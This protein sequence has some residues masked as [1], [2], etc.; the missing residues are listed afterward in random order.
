LE[1]SRLSS[2]ITVSP[3]PEAE[4]EGWCDGRP[5]DVDIGFEIK[6]ATNTV[7]SVS[8]SNWMYC[9]GA[10]HGY[11]GTNGAT[12]I[13]TPEPHLLKASDLFAADS[14]WKKYLTDQCY[15]AMMEKAKKEEITIEVNRDS[16][17]SE[18]AN[19]AAW[20]LTKDGMVV[21]VSPPFYAFGPTEA[22]I[23]WDNL[24]P[25]LLPTAPIPIDHHSADEKAK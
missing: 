3:K 2:A 5:G 21:T 9:H 6:S 11:G 18:V 8:K 15:N 17:Q 22:S 4:G 19:P 13:L 14:E 10:P 12:Y 25:F 7:I 20:G 24:R 23:S 1:H 16:I